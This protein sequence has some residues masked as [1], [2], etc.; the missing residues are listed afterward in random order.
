M[1]IRPAGAPAVG[2]R[3]GPGIGGPGGGGSAGSAE[4]ETQ[5]CARRASGGGSARA[6][7]TLPV[8][9]CVIR[10]ESCVCASIS[11]GWRR[12]APARRQESANSALASRADEKGA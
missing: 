1:S 6:S 7:G 10:S 4:P 9:I 3:G 5:T 2:S 8:R 11:V 12:E